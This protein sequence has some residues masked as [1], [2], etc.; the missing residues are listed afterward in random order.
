[1]LPSRV[2][3]AAGL[4][5]KARGSDGSTVRILRSTGATTSGL[6]LPQPLAV[7]LDRAREHVDIGAPAG[8]ARQRHRPARV[9]AQVVQ[10][11]VVPHEEWAVVGAFRP[12]DQAPRRS[13][14][15]RAAG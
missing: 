5:T 13:A 3:V 14:P 1:M 15:A 8:P 10:V 12:H 2:T 4:R 7:H 9:D 11:D 6:S